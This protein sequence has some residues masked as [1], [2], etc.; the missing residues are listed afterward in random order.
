METRNLTAK[1]MAKTP[2]IVRNC[3]SKARLNP[4]SRLAKPKSCGRGA[5]LRH[6]LGASSRSR[7]RTPPLHLSPSQAKPGISHR[8]VEFRHQPARRESTCKGQFGK[9]QADRTI[10]RP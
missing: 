6:L 1:L 3:E 10:P 8:R 9:T 4:S 7:I 2:K 5:W